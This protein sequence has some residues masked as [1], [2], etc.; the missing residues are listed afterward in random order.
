MLDWSLV[1]LA[2]IADVSVSSVLCFE[3]RGAE[4][5]V[6]YVAGRIQQVLEGEGITFLADDGEGC[7][8][9]L[10]AVPDVDA[11]LTPPLPRLRGEPRWLNVTLGVR[12]P[13]ALG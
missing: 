7:G 13:D 10:G 12:T 11:V 3:M 4:A 5:L 1:D 2:R 6:P 9:R 8:V